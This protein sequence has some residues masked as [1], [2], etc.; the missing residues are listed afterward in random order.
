MAKG[1]EELEL[2]LHDV[3][4]EGTAVYLEKPSDYWGEWSAQLTN[5]KMGNLA[6]KVKSLQY[7]KGKANENEQMLIALGE[8][9][10]LV[11]SFVRI[12]QLKAGMQQEL[13]QQIGVNLKKQTLLTQKRR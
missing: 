9:Y 6:K 3:M 7:I 2:W 4:R 1:L 5:A 12:H 10:L 8:I 13:L 11:R